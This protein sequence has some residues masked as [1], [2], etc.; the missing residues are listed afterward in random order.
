MYQEQFQ[1]LEFH[2]YEI[3]PIPTLKIVSDNEI[4]YAHKFVERSALQQLFAQKGHCD[5]ILIVKNGFVTDTSYGTPIFFD[6]QFWYCSDTP[7]LDGTQRAA[8][9]LSGKLKADEIRLE[10]LEKYSHFKVINAMREMETIAAY[11]IEN[12]VF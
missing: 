3:K 5:D 8:Y 9:L 6:G 4:E 2:P 10:D 1:K 7:L 12:I 11:P